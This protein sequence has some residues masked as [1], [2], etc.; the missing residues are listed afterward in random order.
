MFETGTALKM[1]MRNTQRFCDKQVNS[2]KR[3]LSK[4][5]S[6]WFM[7]DN[8]QKGHPLI[9]QR[10]GSSNKFVKITVMAIREYCQTATATT[11]MIQLEKQQ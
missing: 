11:N 9:F 1:I 4:E 5:N 3:I 2:I 8:N 7:L 6:M 10:F